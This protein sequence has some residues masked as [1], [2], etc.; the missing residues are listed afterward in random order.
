LV[1][2]YS[3]CDLDRKI[4][5]LSGLGKSRTTKRNRNYQTENGSCSFR[6]DRMRALA[7]LSFPNPMLLAMLGLIFMTTHVAAPVVQ[8]AIV[9]Q[10]PHLFNIINQNSIRLIIQQLLPLM[11]YCKTT[12]SENSDEEFNLSV[13]ILDVHAL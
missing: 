9:S 13:R 3:W 2:C 8:L 1:N 7:R 4:N 5:V 11:R 12:A 10:C 6:C